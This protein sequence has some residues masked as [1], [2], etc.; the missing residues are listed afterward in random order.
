MWESEHG[1]EG[2]RSRETELVLVKKESPNVWGWERERGKRMDAAFEKNSDSWCSWPVTV[3]VLLWLC[4]YVGHVYESPH[5]RDSK[6]WMFMFV[7]M[8][9]CMCERK[10][11]RKKGRKK[12]RKKERRGDVSFQNVL[13]GRA[14]PSYAHDKWILWKRN[15]KLCIWSKIEENSKRIQIEECRHSSVD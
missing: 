14:C 2:T 5:G 6:L 4:A 13:L 9:M 11:E 15:I 3:R 10:E 8:C 12:E 1:R 7:C